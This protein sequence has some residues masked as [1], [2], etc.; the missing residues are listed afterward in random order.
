[1]EAGDALPSE[2]SCDAWIVLG[3]LMSAYEGDRFS[4]L[5]A[6]IALLR[7]L[8]HLN[9][10][11]FGICL[12]AQLL[13]AAAGARVYPRRPKEIGFCELR[14]TPAADDDPL[15]KGLSWPM[16]VFEW[17]GDTFDLPVDAI[18]LASTERFENQAFRLGSLVYAFQFHLEFTPDIVAWLKAQCPQ[19]IADLSADDPV[20]TADGQL[21]VGLQ[22]GNEILQRLLAKWCSL[23]SQ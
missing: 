22:R 11:V 7:K 8:L 10:P 2:D 12:G 9:R 4:F 23:W 3:G 6:E 19:D 18:R 20:V 21:H 14:L 13:A 5:D 1:M 17:H 15:L 16:S